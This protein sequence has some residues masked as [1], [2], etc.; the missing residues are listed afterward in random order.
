MGFDQQISKR[1]AELVTEGEKILATRQE[2]NS[3]GRDVTVI[4]PDFVD[5]ARAEE[6]ATC[7]LSFLG[8]VMGKESEHYRRFAENTPRI[9]THSYTVRACAVLRAARSDYDGGYLFD[10]RKRIQAEV[11]DEFLEQAEYLL[12]DGYFA[13]AAVIAGA[14]LEDSLR[15]LCVRKGITMPPAPKLDSMNAELAKAGAYDKLLQKKV[16]WLADIRN[17]AAHGL[18]KGFTADD[19]AEMV[20]A[21]RRFAEEN[22]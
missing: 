16:T 5:S 11:F 2:A 14:V 9:S 12:K 4:M 17:K 22:L 15:Q 6:W 21:V 20:K 8:R 1:L 10:T 19:A 18:W 3:F 7:C 13:V